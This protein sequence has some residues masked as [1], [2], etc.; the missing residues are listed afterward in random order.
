[1]KFS[2]VFFSLL[3]TAIESDAQLFKKK[4]SKN[5]VQEL[6][7]AEDIFSEGTK[8]YTIENFQK[9][10]NLFEKSL[11]I[12]PNSAATNYMIGQ[13]YTRQGNLYK[14]IQFANKAV[15]LD[16]TN[17]YYHLLLAQIYEKKQDF[18][19]AAKVYSNML[20]KVPGTVEYNYDLANVYII[21]NKLEDAI[22]CYDR[23]EK[24][25][26]ISEEVIR[27]KQQIYLKINKLNDAI[28]QGKRLIEAFP[29]ETRYVIGQIELLINNDRI[30]EAEKLANSVI[31]KEPSNPYALMMLSDIYRAKGDE[32]KSQEYLER[33]Y[34]NPELDLD[35]KISI[36]VSKVRQLPNEDIKQQCL[37]LADILIKAHP[38]EAK[39]LAMYADI[40][41]LSGNS[42]VAL[43]Y[44]LQSAR[45]DNTNYKIWQQITLLDQELNLVDSLKVHSEKALELFPNETV[46]WYY[47]GLAN[48]LKRDYKKSTVAFEEGKKLVNV[49]N[50]DLLLQ[51]NT[52]LGDSYN[53]VKDYKK[54]DEAFE[55]ALKIDGNNYI[56]LN[57]YSYYLSLRKDKLEY[58][59]KLSEKVIKE[60]PENET[61][62]DTYA[63]ILYVMKDY[64][65]ARE[66]FE[67]IAGKS[68]NGTIV[69]H[70]GDVLYQLGEKDKALESWKKAKQL[71]DASEL[72]DKKIA[73]KKL[74]E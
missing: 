73:D 28:E 50:K 57:N 30:P 2:F 11:S 20:K 21:L 51:F 14:A 19:D 54:S 35:A 7:Q 70:Y 67:K 52:M 3:F 59:K 58:A 38:N 34:R 55:E 66:I 8:E 13:I 74:Y 44:Y 48:Q 39:A 27:Q 26:G 32:R 49:N 18:N 64:P 65:K 72:I 15:V 36:L 4:E 33:A 40:Q 23:V 41:T 71:G 1:M 61:Y 63:W 45:L 22:K 5:S 16:E 25:F 31:A 62:L 56:V 53:G 69:E 42:R 29:E 60:N 6:Q 24:A 10:L 17:K 12:N 46:F 37:T 9:A 43:E 47:N 68:N